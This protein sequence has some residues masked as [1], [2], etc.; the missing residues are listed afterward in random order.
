MKRKLWL[1][2]SLALNVCLGILLLLNH[3]SGQAPATVMAATNQPVA[4]AA[5]E[6]PKKPA[7]Q[8]TFPLHAKG[9][10]WQQWV[11]ALRDAGV[12]EKLIR[13]TIMADFEDRWQKQQDELQKRFERGEL[14]D[15][16]LALEANQHDNE[17]DAAMRAALGEDGFRQ[18]DLEKTLGEMNLKGLTLTDAETNS[19]Y[20][21]RKDLD[22]KMQELQVAHQKG[23][24]DDADFNKQ[25]RDLQSQ[26][27]QQLKA[28]LGD[29]QYA[30]LQ[31]NNDT[32]AGDVRR[33]LGG[34]AVNDQQFSALLQAQQQWNQANAK[35][36]QQMEDAQVTGTNYDQQ[37]AAINTARDQAYAQ[38]LGT[39]YAA[40]QKAQDAT[41]QNLTRYKNAWQLSDDDIDYLYNVYHTYQESVQEY[42]QQAQAIEKGGQTVDWDAVQKNIADFTQQ[43]EQAV[44]NYLGDGRYGKLQSNSVMM[45]DS[46]N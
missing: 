19:L 20:T 7:P 40:Y 32:S 42:Q 41:Y 23:Q 34:V 27:D 3:R 6:S 10:G 29:Q 33:S 28:T 1:G 8:V 39:N 21:L 14:D 18:W 25:T 43:N 26:F 36:E 22:R 35:L 15:D 9:T 11:Q 38:A 4:V 17:E 45:F 12:P 46:N 16:D 44:R 5:V 24:L 2:L 30:A 31:T 37:L 13:D